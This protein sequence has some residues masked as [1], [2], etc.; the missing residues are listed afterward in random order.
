MLWKKEKKEKIKKYKN[1]NNKII[2]N[3]KCKYYTNNLFY[4]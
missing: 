4:Y 1:F 2:K 3:K